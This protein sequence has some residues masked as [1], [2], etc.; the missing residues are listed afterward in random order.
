MAKSTSIS[1]GKTLS[2]RGHTVRP[3]MKFTLNSIFTDAT[4]L[5]SHYDWILFIHAVSGDQFC[6]RCKVLTGQ[7]SVSKD[8]NV[9][10]INI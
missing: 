8:Q 5:F 2:H 7:H 3:R 9:E 6:A 4:L 10:C 1:N